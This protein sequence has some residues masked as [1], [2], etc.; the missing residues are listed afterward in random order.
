[1]IYLSHI[2]V[3]QWTPVRTFSLHSV[4]ARNTR[5]AS[6]VNPENRCVWEVWIYYWSKSQHSARR[7][8]LLSVQRVSSSHMYPV[9]IQS[10]F[11]LVMMNVSEF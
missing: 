3:I 10:K 2:E 11:C 7:P 1:M 9:R 6:R 8:G 4:L 5:A